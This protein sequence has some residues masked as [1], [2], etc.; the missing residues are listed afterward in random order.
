MW[1]L[2]F[3][4][5]VAV[6]ALPS[7]LK[8]PL[9]RTAFGYRI[10]R[11]VRIGFSPFFGVADCR[12]GDDARIGH[13]NLF[14][15][16]ERLELHDHVRI[17][18]LNLFRGGRRVTV[19]SY[20]AIIRQN[21]FNS[22]IDQDFDHEV[23][24]VLE[25][26]PGAAVAS[27]H[28]LDFSAGVRIGAHSIIAGRNSSFWSHFRQKGTPIRVGDHCYLGSDIRV[29]PGTEVPA[30]SIVALGSVVQGSLV[31]ERSLI[32]GNPASV[33]RLLNDDELRVLS[34]KTRAD[35]PDEF[36][37]RTL[38]ANLLPTPPPAAPPAF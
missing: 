18:F 16:V 3:L 4:C 20:A 38:P 23:E 11:R 6:A 37:S 9:Y 14:Y 5:C 8:V 17:G 10:G 12:I 7:W 24:S 28:W 25:L 30:F 32:G 33:V 31:V 19:G 34:R 13:L 26:G 29:A 21:V 2:K 1:R 27:G 35:I 36:V 15:R 22:I